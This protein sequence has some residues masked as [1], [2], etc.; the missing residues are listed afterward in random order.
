M[1]SVTKTFVEELV[2]ALGP[3]VAPRLSQEL[4]IQPP[5]AAQILPVVAPLLMGA[6]KRRKDEGGASLL[7]SILGKQADPDG[8]DDVESA[9]SRRAAEPDDSP[10]VGGLLGGLGDQ[11]AAVLAE[12]LGLST[13]QAR[14]AIYILAPLV[15]GYLMKQSPSNPTTQGRGLDLSVITEVLDRNGDGSVLDDVGGFLLSRLMR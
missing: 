10:S 3:K 15:L 2:E 4:G 1:N 9:I 13:A 6:L 14:N 8:V 12:K 5:V 11:A 7:S